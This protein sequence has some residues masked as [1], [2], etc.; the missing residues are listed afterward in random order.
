M[1]LILSWIPIVICRKQPVVPCSSAEVEYRALAVTTAA[2]ICLCRLLFEMHI[3]NL[4]PTILYSDSTSAGHVAHNDVFHECTKHLEIDCHFV[5]QHI[6]QRTAILCLI[7]FTNQLADFFTN[8][9]LPEHLHCL[10]HS[11]S[12]L[13]SDHRRVVKRHK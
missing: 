8:C 2:I 6:R 10:V 4:K 3:H 7:S 11:L 13:S 12:M 5:C 9:H 1:L